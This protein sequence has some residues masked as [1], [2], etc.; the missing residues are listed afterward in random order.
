METV[1]C[2]LSAEYPDDD[3]ETRE[4]LAQLVV[5]KLGE[6]C[7]NELRAEKGCVPLFSMVES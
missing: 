6:M 4:T 7:A 5:H 3:L 2:A 1:S